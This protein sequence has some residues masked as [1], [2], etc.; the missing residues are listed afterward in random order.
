MSGGLFIFLTLNRLH[1]IY[2]Q[3]YFTVYLYLLLHLH[4][5]LHL[6]LYSFGCSIWI[7]DLKYQTGQGLVT[8]LTKK[9]SRWPAIHCCS[10]QIAKTVRCMRPR[11]L[12][13][14]FSRYHYISCIKYILIHS[15]LTKLY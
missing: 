14:E 9:A 8:K 3:Y 15:K 2:L 4:L 5:R 7:P 1:F 11:R 13:R 6:Y 10:G 12:L